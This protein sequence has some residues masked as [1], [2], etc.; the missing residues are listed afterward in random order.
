MGMA[1]CENPNLP[2]FAG[3]NPARGAS[4]M[5]RLR[6]VI[7]HLAEIEDEADA[8]RDPLSHPSIRSMS[9]REIADLPLST[10]YGKDRS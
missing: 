3:G 7:R 5:N 9:T 8:W 2:M 6:E 1:Q 4:L 10:G